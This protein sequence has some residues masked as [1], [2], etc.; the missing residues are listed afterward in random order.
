M[1]HFLDLNKINNRFKEEFDIKLKHFF[2]EG[3]Y[4]LG[5]EVEMFE[6]NFAT[7][8][9]VSNCIG[10]SNGLDALTLILKAYKNL[11]LL[12]DNDEVLVP[13]NTYIATILSIVHANLNPV[14]VEPNLDTYT[15]DVFEI[16][17]QIT[18]KTKAIIAVHLY[19]QL[20]DMN[21]INNM[22]QKFNL[23][24]IEDAAQAHGATN[25]NNERA[26]NLGHAAAFSFY[27]SKNLGAL[28]DGGAVTTN[29]KKLANQIKLLRNYGSEKKYS[30]SI[31]GYNCRLDE[32]QALFLNIK[33]KYLNSDNLKRQ[34]IAHE[35]LSKIKNDKLILPIVNDK[36]SHVFHVFV[37]RTANRTELMQ[38]L[39]I[40]QIGCLIHY[41]IAPYKQEA[42]KKLISDKYP[43]SDCIHDTI[44]SIPIS[45]VMTDI[46]VNK[47]I[48][49]LN[50]Y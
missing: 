32:I 39:E 10:V 46:E 33:L 3:Q 11:G 19:G 18:T 14:L 30:N 50:N 27:P 7:Y 24:V 12:K 44:I 45:P 38:Y 16:E 37:L 9:G 49:I 15:I 2:D 43:I 23:L 17:K 8:C 42:L 25:L 31:I 26:G 29:D 1:I 34:Q 35:Y 41:P 40:N 48:T 4:I 13:A 28:G 6:S 47:V 5:S 20:A 21:V 22:S 36:N